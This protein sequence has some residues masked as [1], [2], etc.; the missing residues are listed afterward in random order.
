MP[1]KA[2]QRP[3]S[4]PEPLSPHEVDYR[5]IVLVC[6]V[7][8]LSQIVYSMLRVTISYRAVELGLPPIWVGIIAG[9]S[10]ILPMLLAVK[11]GRFVDRGNDAT[12]TWI[13]ATVMLTTCL[14]LRFSR[15]QEMELLAF[16]ALLGV[17]HMFMMVS[18]QMLSVRSARNDMSRET[19]LGHYM[20]AAALGQGLGPFIVGWLGGAQ[21]LPPTRMLF[22]TAVVV[23]VLSLLFALR[24]RQPASADGSKKASATV[25]P[26]GDLLRTPGVPT[27]MVASVITVAS[28]DLLVIYLPLLGAE[29]GIDVAHIGMLLTV[30]S[31]FSVICRMFYPPM[32]R[33]V[34]RVPL[35]VITMMAGAVSLLLISL[36][37]PLWAMYAAMVSIGFGL[38]VAATLSI[39][40]MVDAVPPSARGVA[41]SLRITGNRLGQ[42]SIP[43]LAG[44]AAAVA[45]TGAIFATMGLG[46]IASAITVQRVRGSKKTD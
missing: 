25:M 29:R 9:T 30:R 15:A 46:L 33:A 3:T 2:S 23:G 45:G 37:M 32:M 44:L 27:L 7:S 14:G 11:T 21:R 31:F 34:G 26:I 20:V 41:L 24:I 8:T 19:A 18:L 4:A 17:G 40:N 1:D 38:G 28:Q 36:P 43:L 22:A 6:A 10:A 12:M 35:T 42:V 16:T 39:S 5:L 13:G